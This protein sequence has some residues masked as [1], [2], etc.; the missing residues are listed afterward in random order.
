[1]IIKFLLLTILCVSLSTSSITLR[2][3]IIVEESQS[4]PIKPLA[5]EVIGLSRVHLDGNCGVS[6][7]NLGNFITDSFVDWNAQRYESD[8]AWTDA[9]LAI[10]ENNSIKDSFEKSD[11]LTNESVDSCLAGEKIVIV[12][13]TGAVL[14]EA[15]EHSM[16]NFVKDV[17]I[18]EFLQVSGM[19]VV[20]NVSRSSGDRVISVQLL[21]A[22]CTVPALEDLDTTKNYKI[23]MQESLAKGSNGFTM[24]SDKIVKTIETTDAEMFIEYLKKKSPIYPAVEW[25]V[26]VYSAA[27]SVFISIA[28]L[29]S[30]AVVTIFAKF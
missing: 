17:S 26:T 12:E 6:E 29:V 27:S 8:D 3:K 11:D 5:D 13:V 14:K 21:C 19:N 4:Q 18:N 25:R 28:L 1:M 16:R 22:S 20:Y 9:A 24:F 15:L 10:I 23:L 30:T 2:D 7:C